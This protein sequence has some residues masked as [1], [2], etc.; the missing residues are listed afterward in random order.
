MQPVI[1]PAVDP[2]EPFLLS[3]DHATLRVEIEPGVWGIVVANPKDGKRARAMPIVVV[4]VI[5]LEPHGI[6]DGG[7]GHRRARRR[8][9][10]VSVEPREGS[11][12]GRNR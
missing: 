11:V 9:H 3:H 6:V 7:A 10:G 4:R 12:L 5:L 2:A 1:Q 8:Q